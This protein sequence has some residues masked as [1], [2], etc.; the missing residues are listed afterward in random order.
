MHAP[1]VRP[2]LKGPKSNAI[3]PVLP[4][5][6]VALARCEGRLARCECNGVRL[7]LEIMADLGHRWS[8][9]RGDALGTGGEDGL[10][11]AIELAGE[12][13]AHKVSRLELRPTRVPPAKFGRP[14]RAPA[15][16]SRTAALA[17]SSRGSCRVICGN[18]RQ[19]GPPN[20]VPRSCPS[21]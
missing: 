1:C 15:L 2:R 14:S 18:H 16:P 12:F 13:P 20:E 11:N 6:G 17:G 7:L 9:T 4:P 3:R 21:R 19:A 10:G 8:T 5:K